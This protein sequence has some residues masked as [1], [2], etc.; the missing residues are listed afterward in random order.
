MMNKHRL[1]K[2]LVTDVVDAKAT[3]ETALELN[4]KGSASLEHLKGLRALRMLYL[5][6]TSVTEDN[7]KKFKKSMN[8]LAIF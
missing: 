8:S 4:D 1:W 5:K 6:E 7:V 3:N 2:K